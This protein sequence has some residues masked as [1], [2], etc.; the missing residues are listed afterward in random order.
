MKVNYHSDQGAKNLY[1]SIEL[2]K[3]MKENMRRTILPVVQ[4][5]ASYAHAENILY[6]TI[7]DDKK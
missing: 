2:M 7:R 5:N 3:C 6:A 1:K 4:R